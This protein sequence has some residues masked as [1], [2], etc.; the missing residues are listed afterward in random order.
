MLYVVIIFDF[1]GLLLFDV[2]PGKENINREIRILIYL[3]FDFSIAV[4][5]FEII[6]RIVLRESSR[7]FFWEGGEPKFANLKLVNCIDFALTLLAVSGILFHR[8]EFCGLQIIRLLPYQRDIK[9]K[10]IPK[11]IYDELN[12]NSEE[13]REL[14]INWIVGLNLICFVLSYVRRLR[15][16]MSIF[17]FFYV[18]EF[19]GVFSVAVYVA[20]IVWR[21]KKCDG[22]ST[23]EKFKKFWKTDWASFDFILM[24]I[25]LTAIP[26]ILIHI[27]YLNELALEH[28]VNKLLYLSDM[29]L[30]DW[31]QRYSMIAKLLKPLSM[32]RIFRSN[33]LK[34]IT[35]SIVGSFKKVVWSLV[36]FI[37][38][39]TI[40]G[41]F[42]NMMFSRSEHFV[43]FGRSL[44][45]LF[46]IMTFDSWGVT[47]QEVEKSCNLAGTLRHYV[48]ILFFYSFIIMVSYIMWSVIQGIIVNQVQEA[49]KEESTNKKSTQ[50]SQEI[51]NKIDNLT[52][53]LEE[54]K[55]LV[56][57]A[58]FYSNDFSTTD[59]TDNTEK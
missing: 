12:L 33:N 40:Y 48:L 24:L 55:K 47:M 8:F 5:I 52:K 4:F 54:L 14:F 1:I 53:E 17:G 23:R 31:V 38:L 36:Y 57:D 9:P 49:N 26:E 15:D 30:K 19:I 2:Y 27:A 51:L 37:I 13:K 56:N 44:E 42:G 10:G 41:A 3:G 18:A 22:N 50:T 34:F 25:S 45:T 35:K 6:A 32:L 58:T 28:S 46:R 21:I 43:S 7:S 39:F 11:K 59:Y 16:V 29:K 20:D